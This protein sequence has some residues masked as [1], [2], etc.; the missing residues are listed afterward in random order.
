MAS[1]NNIRKSGYYKSNK[2]IRPKYRV[3]RFINAPHVRLIDENGDVL[4]VKAIS[5]ALRITEEKGLDL[6]EVSPLADPPVCKIQ[7][8]GQF[9]YKQE[10]LKRKQQAKIKKVQ[11]KG[12]RL[13][14]GIA[15]HDMEMRRKNAQKFLEN[16][17]RVK[18]EMVLSGREQQHIQRAFER[19]QNFTQSL[20]E[21]SSVEERPQR[22]G[23][24]LFVLIRPKNMSQ[25]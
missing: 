19:L 6:V 13:T 1:L 18:I 21:I 4:G 22:M 7:D 11:V 5:E 9:K 10:K 17:D 15:E 24:K 3:N 2:P 25:K 23:R 14:F 12:I 20:E 16:G 8:F